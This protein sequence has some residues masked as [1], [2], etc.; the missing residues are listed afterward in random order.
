MGM[1]KTPQVRA[2]AD[3]LAVAVTII[4]K[5]ETAS[6]RT[7]VSVEFEAGA[8]EAAE[9]VME[10]AA[11]LA[12]A[13]VEY[14]LARWALDNVHLDKERPF[15]DES[16][17]KALSDIIGVPVESIK[18]REKLKAALWAAATKK[19]SEE[20]GVQLEDLS[21]K[22]K[23][24]KNVLNLLAVQIGKAVPGL[25]LHDLSDRAQTRD[26]VSLY[27]SRIVSDFTGINFTDIT[28][29]ERIKEDLYAFAEPHVAAILN[30]ESRMDSKKPLK[31]DKKSVK[32][33]QAQRRFRQKHGP[34][35]SYERYSAVERG[36]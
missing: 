33:R 5:T 18:D 23:T 17:S 27:A 9:A 32:N 29:R 10:P 14:W 36:E 6:G 28:S 34:R 2:A 22:K 25:E 12:A 20:T 8:R 15:S 35:N 3:A 7:E 24:R 11:I 16:L 13:A 31:M 30:E 26:D 19:V 1:E 4:D 21:D